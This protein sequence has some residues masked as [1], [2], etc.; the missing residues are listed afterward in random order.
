MKKGAI[1]I[2]FVFL[3]LCIILFINKCDIIN[4][5]NELDPISFTSRIGTDTED[6][7]SSIVQARDRAYFLLGDASSYN[8]KYSWLTKLDKYGNEEWM[9]LYGYSYSI[10]MLISGSNELVSLFSNE[11]Q[12]RF[13]RL[14]MNGD[15]L[16]TKSL[17]LFYFS[18]KEAGHL[19]ECLDG[20]YLVSG[21][22]DS[23]GGSQGPFHGYIAKINSAASTL[24]KFISPNSVISATAESPNGYLY[25]VGKDKGEPIETRKS[26]VIKLDGNGNLIWKKSY[27]IFI[28]YSAHPILVKSE[29][30]MLICGFSDLQNLLLMKINSDGDIIWETTYSD[31]YSQVGGNS[32]SLGFESKIIVLGEANKNGSLITLLITFD[33]YGNILSSKEF[34]G[35]YPSSLLLTQDNGIIFCAQSAEIN[36]GE[37]DVLVYKIAP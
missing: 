30:E 13:V 16:F 20:N 22:S 6:Y 31:S 3:S 28:P 32:I 4:H 19:L 25:A 9:K 33:D 7:G 17:K 23:L 5:N 11:G 8:N 34:E 37:R 15:Q 18:S 1:I 24:W 14:N 12:M 10:D 35:E 29:M 26:F 27:E 2:Q 36:L 21:Y